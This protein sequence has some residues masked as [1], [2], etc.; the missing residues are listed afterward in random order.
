[1]GGNDYL[2][3][4]RGRWCV[5]VRLP[6]DLARSLGRT[7]VVRSLGTSDL[8][9]ARQRRRAALAVILT[10]QASQTESDGWSPSRAWKTVTDSSDAANGFSVT[11]TVERSRRPPSQALSSRPARNAPAKMGKGGA[12]SLK[13]LME[14]WL[15]ENP[16]GSTKQTLA[17]HRVAM[18]P[19]SVAS[20]SEGCPHL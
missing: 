2:Q 6:A 16:S 7:H 13:T 17:M 20:P 5:R 12:D 19:F 15:A 4:R 1:M 8:V 14:R 3:L 9:I 10:W 18:R 11:P